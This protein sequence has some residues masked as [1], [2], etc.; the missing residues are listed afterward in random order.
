MKVNIIYLVGVI[1]SGKD[2]YVEH[3]KVKEGEVIHE[4]KIGSTLTKI[5]SDIYGVDLSNKELYE[6]WK[7]T[8]NN[9]EKL[10]T[11]AES[12]KFHLGNE[13]FAERAAIEILE[14]IKRSANIKVLTFIISDSCFPSD[15]QTIYSYVEGA[16]LYDLDCILFYKIHFCNYKSSKYSIIPTQ[17]RE[18]FPIFLINEGFETGREWSYGE[19]KYILNQYRLK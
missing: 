2:H 13:V 15:I 1:G 18:K 5:A 12:I 9:R 19:F 16:L 10:I 11:L 3:Y 4:I 14:T 6:K 7:Y 17:P 8:E